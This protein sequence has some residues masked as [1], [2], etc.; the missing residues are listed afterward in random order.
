M[1]VVQ[2]NRPSLSRGVT[3][4][5]LLI[6]L[7][8][9]SIVVAAAYASYQVVHTLQAR[10]Q[11]LS[12]IH[13]SGREGLRLL[14]CDLRMA[15]FV[16]RNN[17]TFSAL[18][19]SITAPLTVSSDLALN[20]SGVSYSNDQLTIL[21]DDVEGANSSGTDLRR[22]TTYQISCSAGRLLLQQQVET[23]SGGS[24][25]TTQAM[26]P[27]VSDIGN[28]QFQ[29][30]AAD[31]SS[32]ATPGSEAIERIEIAFEVIGAGVQQGLLQGARQTVAYSATVQSCNLGC[33]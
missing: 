14:S 25:S 26:A 31:G 32:S 22:R 33:G 5:E 17:S 2:A 4:V 28:L 11:D 19:R 27:I 9:G 18:P 29:F 8:V 3:L 21:Y 12:E 24:Y 16:N 20:C 6:S 30:M 1:C 10:S 7:V 13:Q 15:G 23:S